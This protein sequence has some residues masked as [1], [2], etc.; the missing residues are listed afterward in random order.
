MDSNVKKVVIIG[1]SSGIGLSLAKQYVDA[2]FLVGITGRRLELLKS[3]QQQ[4]LGKVFIKQMDVSQTSQAIIQLQHLIS[5]MG[6]MDIIIINAGIGFL[7]KR[8]N[9]QK[10]EKV[11][12]TNVSGFC[13]IASTSLNYFIQQKSG[14]LVSISSIN[15]L[16]GSDTAPAYAASK[17]FVS[18]YV[19]GLRKK[20]KKLKLPIDVTDIQPGFVDTDMVRGEHLF[21]VASSTKAA[22]QIIQAIK[23]RK[24][25]VYISKRWRLIAWAMKL[26]PD[27]VY[28]KI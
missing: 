1:A 18:N 15:A 6:G 7:N 9:W 23:K 24:K 4:Y 8:L 19:E 12:N 27:W 16:R 26:M 25:L 17:A 5:Q 14:Q 22:Q 21:W 13:A 20:I 3:F 2:G 11:I 28:N 10:E